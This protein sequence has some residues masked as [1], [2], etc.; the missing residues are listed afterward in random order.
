MSKIY[1]FFILLL[2]VYYSPHLLLSQEPHMADSKENVLILENMTDSVFYTDPGQAFYYLLQ[3]LKMSERIGYEEGAAKAKVSLG[4][5]YHHMEKYDSAKYY[6]MAG[7]KYG[8]KADNINVLINSI[9]AIGNLYTDNMMFDSMLLLFN[10]GLEKSLL[11]KNKE[12]QAVMYY[13]L[14][15]LFTHEGRFDTSVALF[16]SAIDIYRTKGDTTN[17]LTVLNTMAASIMDAGQ[18]ER[19]LPMLKEAVRLSEHLQPQSIYLNSLTNLAICYKNLDS[20]QKAEELYLKVLALEKGKPAMMSRDLMNLG[21]L[22][23]NMERYQKAGFYLDSS[24][25]ICQRLELA[26]GFV[27]YNLYKGNLFKAQKNY[28]S[29]IVYLDE[30]LNLAKPYHL[31]TEQLEMTL[32]MYEMYADLKQHD[33]AL[34]YYISYSTLKDSIH[35]EDVRKQLAEI[36]NKYEHEKDL[37]QIAELNEENLRIKSHQKMLALAGIAVVFLL[38]LFYAYKVFRHRNKILKLKLIEEEKEKLNIEVKTKE[39]E[40]ALNAMHMI[41]MND[42][43][44]KVSSRLQLVSRHVSA[45]NRELLEETVKEMEVC[46]P[47]EIWNEFE[48]RF[49]KVHQ[50]FYKELYKKHP[51]LSPTEYKVCSFIRLNMTSKDIAAITN[52]SIRTIE[53]TRNSIRKKFGLNP[54]ESLATYLLEF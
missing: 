17:E 13:G 36:E 35:N 16:Q 20:H 54:D 27:L 40:L 7:L 52:R 12:Y 6:L 8:R 10:E 34:K 41:R 32:S 1:Y 44:Y 29:A 49:K 51:D 46:S 53:S 21:I 14:G 3:R 43:A 18:T 5:Y 47:D 33:S 22:Y 31:I 2:A 38:S 37:K 24:F 39:K 19:A 42:I 28:D 4:Y 45:Q 9:N 30:A 11:D 25:R 15:R 26:Y 48:T 23:L 50:G